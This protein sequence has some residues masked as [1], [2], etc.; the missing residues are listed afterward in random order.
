[1]SDDDVRA[2]LRIALTDEPPMGLDPDSAAASARTTVRR[3]RAVIATGALTAVLAAGAITVASMRTTEAPP[4]ADGGGPVEVTL[5]V[6]EFSACGPTD[7]N[8]VCPYVI[9]EMERAA[10]QAGSQ[11]RATTDWEILSLSPSK[12]SNPGEGFQGVL[13]YTDEVGRGVLFVEAYLW[14]DRE[15][16]PNIEPGETCEVRGLQDESRVEVS[17]TPGDPPEANAVGATHRR[18]DGVV[19]GVRAY[20]WDYMQRGDP[21]RTEPPFTVEQ[22]IAI[23]TDPEIRPTA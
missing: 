12:G 1:M 23:A 9:A 2:A 17:V 8:P 10:Q 4:P 6:P 15:T 3:R 18:L 7:S 21:V 22:L 14:P 11:N 5:A 19:V 20:E 16:C 13:G